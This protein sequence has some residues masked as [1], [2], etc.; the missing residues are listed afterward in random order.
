MGKRD[1][2]KP[3][4]VVLEIK[5]CSECPHHKTCNQWSS[6]GWDRME[7]WICTKMDGKKVAGGVEWHDVIPIPDWCPIRLENIL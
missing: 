2:V 5:N 6:D 1:E 7:D 4:P 3:I